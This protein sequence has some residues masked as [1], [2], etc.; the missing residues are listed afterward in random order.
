[1]SSTTD[2]LPLRWMVYTLLIV[3]AAGAMLGRILSVANLHDP[4]TYRA[5][6]DTESPRSVWPKTH[7]EP[8]PTLGGNDRSRWSTIRALVDDGTYEIGRRTVDRQTGSFKD[9]GIV[10]E[11][12]WRT[13]D[14]VLHPDTH[15]YFSSKPPLL[16]TLLAGEYW[17]LK[18]AFGLSITEDPWTVVRALLLTVNWLPFIFYLVLLARLLEHFGTTDW[19]RLYVLAAAAFAT[20]LTPFAMALNNHSV[21]TYSALF[22]LYPALRIWSSLSE[23]GSSDPGSPLLFAAAGFF[24]AFAACNELPAASFMAF[25]FL[26]LLV[27]APGRTLAFFVPAAVVPVAALLWT[28]YL[29]IGELVP[30]YSKLQTPWYQYEGSYWLLETD[31]VRRGIDWAWQK[32]TKT[33]YALHLLVGHHGLF[34]LTPIWL[35]A[36]AG[37]LGIGWHGSTQRMVAALALALTVAVLTFYL[38]VAPRMS[39]NYGGWT[40]GPRWLMWLTPFWLLTLLPVADWLAGSRWGRGL[41]YVCLGISVL[42]VSYPTWNPWRHPWIYNWMEAMQWIQY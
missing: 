12:G 30:A 9:K 11:D 2:S 5:E 14:K 18:Q 1:M 24:A 37:M 7:P 19:G 34:S 33:E 3:V 26:L 28:N 16:P 36:A 20:L 23:P 29:A 39:N 38:F 13:L 25:L 31:K 6:D 10:T 21:A 4:R 15:Q 32:E 8:V 42:S 41:A 22:A 40:C 35:L 17:L 27:Y